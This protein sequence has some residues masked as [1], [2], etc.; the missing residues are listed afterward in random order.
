MKAYYDFEKNNCFFQTVFSNIVVKLVE[1][2]GTAIQVSGLASLITRFYPQF[3]I[4]ENVKYQVRNI[5]VDIL[6]F[7]HL[8][9]RYEFS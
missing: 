3:C 6:S 4:S 8:T 7:G 1:F 2:Y 9:F 5:E